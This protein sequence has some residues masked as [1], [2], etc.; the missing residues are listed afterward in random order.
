VV[1]VVDLH[2][3]QAKEMRVEKKGEIKAAA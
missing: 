1:L 2:A 3:E